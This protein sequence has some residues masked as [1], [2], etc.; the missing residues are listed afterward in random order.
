MALLEQTPERDD[1]WGHRTF[2]VVSKL[3][4]T[5]AGRE[6]GDLTGQAKGEAYRAAL[7]D[8]PCWATEGAARRW[9]RGDC[10]AQHNYTWPPAP[11]VLRGIARQTECAVRWKATE[12]QQLL[13][14]EEERVFGAAH[15]AR[16]RARL[17]E[18]LVGLAKPQKN[19]RAA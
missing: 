19:G 11:A 16:M 18:L 8:V 1:R 15:C 10:G 13:T 7:D 6:G 14:A 9:Y 4:M 12:L 3:L 17:S 2:V 5:L